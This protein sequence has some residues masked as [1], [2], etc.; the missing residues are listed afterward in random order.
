MQKE[1]QKKFPVECKKL[2]NNFKRLSNSFKKKLSSS[3]F[4]WVEDLSRGQAWPATIVKCMNDAKGTTM[5]T[6]DYLLMKVGSLIKTTVYIGTSGNCEKYCYGTIVAIHAPRFISVMMHG[7]LYRDK[8][9]FL[10][11]YDLDETELV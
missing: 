9:I 4:I 8:I 11:G 5:K 2:Q 7:G 3:D 10:R 6:K 1:M